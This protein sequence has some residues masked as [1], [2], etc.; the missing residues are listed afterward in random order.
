MTGPYPNDPEESQ[1]LSSLAA[2]TI[3]PSTVLFPAGWIG[4]CIAGRE[5]EGN[6]PRKSRL[7]LRTVHIN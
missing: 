1:P 6:A 5:T 4:A 2:P 7:P 3:G